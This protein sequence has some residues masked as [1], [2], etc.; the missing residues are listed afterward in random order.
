MK[1]GIKVL[2]WP[3][4][5]KARHRKLKTGLRGNEKTQYVGSEGQQDFI[6][7]LKLR[8]RYVILITMSL[9]H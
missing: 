4:L 1:S 3:E 2:V 7:M 5:I 9:D 8:S 6:K